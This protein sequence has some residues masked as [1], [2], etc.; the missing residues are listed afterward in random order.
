MAEILNLDAR[1]GPTGRTTNTR[2]L[3]CRGVIESSPAFSP[4]VTSSASLFTYSCFIWQRPLWLAR[5]TFVFDDCLYQNLHG[6]QT[7]LVSSPIC[8]TVLVLARGFRVLSGNWL[9][10]ASGKWRRACSLTSS[11][12]SGREV[13]SRIAAYPFVA[14]LAAIMSAVAGIVLR[15]TVR[16]EHAQALG[17]CRAAIA[18]RLFAQAVDRWIMSYV[19]I[20]DRKLWTS[21]RSANEAVE[22]QLEH[23]LEKHDSWFVCS[24]DCGGESMSFKATQWQFFFCLFVVSQLPPAGLWCFQA[25]N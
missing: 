9:R 7:E 24:R 23:T 5:R 25:C 16:S 14:M 20:V 4:P 15:V 11:Q 13:V 8:F 22:V 2:V 6:A 18:P 21:S 10:G 19:G 1:Q 3:G 12:S 17:C